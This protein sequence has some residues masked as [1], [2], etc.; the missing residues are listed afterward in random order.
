MKDNRKEI[1]NRLEILMEGSR[2]MVERYTELHG[3]DSSSVNQWRGKALAYRVSIAVVNNV[4][5]GK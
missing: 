4:F 2:R 5:D 3:E 1:L